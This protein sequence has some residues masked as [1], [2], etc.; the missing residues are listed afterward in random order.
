MQQFNLIK[1]KAPEEVFVVEPI[2]GLSEEESLVPLMAQMMGICTIESTL[3]PGF[4]NEI[5][6]LPEI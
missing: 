2:A 1:E 5:N 6:E 3:R 4:K